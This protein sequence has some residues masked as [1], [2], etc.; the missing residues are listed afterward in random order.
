MQAAQAHSQYYIL[1]GNVLCVVLQSLQRPRE[2]ISLLLKPILEY[3]FTSS[4]TQD[5]LL[6]QS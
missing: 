3:S 1:V 6:R 5:I 2:I 4:S